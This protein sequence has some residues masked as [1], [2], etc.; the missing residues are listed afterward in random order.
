[1]ATQ[2]NKRNLRLLPFHCHELAG[3][4]PVPAICVKAHNAGLQGRRVIGILIAIDFPDSGIEPD[5]LL[6][7]MAYAYVCA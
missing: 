3:L 6:R 7:H 2:I 5:L 4:V 1:M